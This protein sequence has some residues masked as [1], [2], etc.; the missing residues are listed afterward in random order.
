MTISR[1]ACRLVFSSDQRKASSISTVEHSVEKIVAV[2]LR[3]HRLHERDVGQTAS[4]CGVIASGIRADRTDGALDGVEQRQAGEHPHGELLLG[5][6]ERVPGGMSLDTEPSRAAR[7]CRSVV[8]R[9]RRPSRPTTRFQLIADRPIDQ[10]NSIATETPLHHAVCRH[11]PADKPKTLPLVY[12]RNH[13]RPNTIRCVRKVR[14]VSGRTGFASRRKPGIG[15]D[16]VASQY[17]QVMPLHRARF[18]PCSSRIP[19]AAPRCSTPFGP[20]LLRA[21]R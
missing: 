11:S 15:G 16:R 6:G 20:V 10:L 7:S 17:S 2:A 4:S 5:A 21:R 19:A 3:V 14:R 18:L 1:G 13:A 8:P 9:P 12:A